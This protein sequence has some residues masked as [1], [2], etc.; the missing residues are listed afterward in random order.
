MAGVLHRKVLAKGPLSQPEGLL[1]ES[2]EL[3]PPSPGPGNGVP[4]L[5]STLPARVPV[6]VGLFS[7]P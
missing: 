5:L 6:L 7:E 2:E 3:L 4:A 1:P